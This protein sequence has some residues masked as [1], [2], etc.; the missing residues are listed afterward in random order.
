M[1]AKSYPIQL[2]IEGRPVL[3]VGGG[4]VATRK[5]ERLVSCRAN[6]KVVAPEV[7][8]PVRRL[9]E[10]ADVELAL[11][12]ATDSDAEGMFMVIAA[13][14]D[15]NV[16]AALCRAG[17]RCG[18]LVSSVDAPEQS[19]FT[20]PSWAHTDHVE[21]T[22]ST[23]G[24]APA[25]SRRLGKELARWLLAGPDRFVAELSRARRVLKG[26]P[27]AAARL[28]SLASGPLF[29]ACAS[30]DDPRIQ[31]LVDAALEQP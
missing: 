2:R 9:A 16:N 20:L 12:P 15:A 8:A 30:G 17:R 6:V 23:G 28:R 13:S 31:G 14:N 29:E 26:R 18:A 22:I 5:I 3:V 7:S 25:A 21:A 27:D 11:R 24:A 10:H 4:R 19:D 1:S